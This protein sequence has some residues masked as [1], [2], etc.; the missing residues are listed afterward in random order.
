MPCSP[1]AWAALPVTVHRRH[2][3]SLCR[4]SPGRHGRPC[5]G[6][7]RRP[8]REPR[9]AG[10]NSHSPRPP[11]HGPPRLPLPGSRPLASLKPAVCPSRPS[12]SLLV[13]RA[14]R[15]PSPSCGRPPDPDVRLR[16]PHHQ[17]PHTITPPHHHLPT[18]SPPHTITSQHH[19]PPTPSPPNTITPPHTITP[20]SAG[21]AGLLPCLRV[22]SLP[23]SPGP[24][25]PLEPPACPQ[26]VRSKG[27]CLCEVT[28]SLC[29]VT[30]RLCEVIAYLCEVTRR[31]SSDIL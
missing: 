17:S 21:Q 30:L 8:T 29:E 25:P 9:P 13:H 1:A 4:R 23:A 3:S 14:P 31:L 6:A 11:L 28:G 20:V 27:I 16:P 7:E 15:G 18:P 22:K 24:S 19:H 26:H 5:R 12:R 2:T 10:P